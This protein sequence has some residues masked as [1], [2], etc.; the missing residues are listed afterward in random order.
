MSSNLHNA[1]QWRLKNTRQ[2]RLVLKT[3]AQS[4]VLLQERYSLS[5]ISFSMPGSTSEGKSYAKSNLHVNVNFVSSDIKAIGPSFRT[6]ISTV[7]TILEVQD[8]KHR[9]SE[10]NRTNVTHYIS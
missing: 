6:S 7:I 4:A 9:S 1:S 5:F 2:A 8:Q 10:E 3:E